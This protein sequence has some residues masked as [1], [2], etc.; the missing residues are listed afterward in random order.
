MHW[1]LWQHLFCWELYTEHI[2][3]QPR[4][5]ARVGGFTLQV[6]EK[7][8]NLYIPCKM[9]TNNAG[10]SRGWFYLQNDD[11]RLP[12]YTGKILREKLDVWG[13]GMSPPDQ[14][15]KLKVFTDALRRLADKGRT[16]AAVIA[17]FYWQRVL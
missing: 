8:G 4:R 9:T 13:W 2:Q 6:R 5:A 15:A 10:W 17:T 3:G 12:A 1:E 14:Q 11:G 7:R 16:A